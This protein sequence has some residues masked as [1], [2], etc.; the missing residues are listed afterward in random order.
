MIK[1]SES[2]TKEVKE[3]LNDIGRDLF[4]V[5]DD[6]VENYGI[7]LMGVFAGIT[8]RKKEVSQKTIET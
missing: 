4:S 7:G 2:T 8:Y 3:I 6:F 1:Y 5:K